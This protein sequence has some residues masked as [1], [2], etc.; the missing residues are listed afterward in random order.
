[1]FQASHQIN[2]FMTMSLGR[3]WTAFSI[4]LA[5]VTAHG[6]FYILFGGFYF[7]IGGQMYTGIN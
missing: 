7:L 5:Q 1:M 3:C 6:W 2:L 4:L